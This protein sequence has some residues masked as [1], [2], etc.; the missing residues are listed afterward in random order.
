MPG[1]YVDLDT[2][3]NPS[4]ATNKA[5]ASWGDQIRANQDLFA[6]RYTAGGARTTASIALANNTNT[7]ISWAIERWDND[8]MLTASGTTFTVQ[9]DHGGLYLCSASVEIE[10]NASG[11]RRLYARVNG[12]DLGIG[13]VA[14][15]ASGVATHLNVAF[16]WVFAVGDYLEWRA[17][18]NSG[19]ALDY[20]AEASFTWLAL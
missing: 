14:D 16:P 20:S 13:A 2:I 15:G 9:A 8:S 10:A 5:P 18:Q 7:T 3:H 6:N 17:Y 1:Q 11:I 19:G 12:V 4:A